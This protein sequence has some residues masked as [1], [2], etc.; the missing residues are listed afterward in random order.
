MSSS[1]S[2]RTLA[3]LSLSLVG[4]AGLAC[5][6]T[7][8]YGSG[9]GGGSNYPNPT[10]AQVIM[11][12]GAR[13]KTTTAFSPDPFTVS[14]NGA[15]SVSVEFGNDDNETHH[16]VESVAN[17]TF[18]SGNLLKGTTYTHNFTTAGTYNYH[19]SIHPNMVGQIKV[20]P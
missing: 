4:L 9:G 8:S 7:T 17:P 10:G 6:S 11:V 18:D 15:A 14:L 19:C 12:H 13:N 2:R 16:V 5:G 3:L 20:N 1:R